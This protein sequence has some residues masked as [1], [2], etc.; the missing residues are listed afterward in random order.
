[1]RLCR[2]HLGN[3]VRG[4]EREFIDMAELLKD[5]A[6]T[7]RRRLGRDCEEAIAFSPG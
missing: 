5:N 4:S 7:E 3:S 2:C 6:E 1:M